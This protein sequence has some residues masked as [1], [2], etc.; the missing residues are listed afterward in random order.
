MLAA[1]AQR[2]GRQQI[3][4][5]AEEQFAAS[6]F[7]STTTA[8][9][10]KA[11][12]VREAMLHVHFGTRRKLF[13]EVIER[14]AQERV[15][16]LRTRF[17]SMPKL[18][19]LECV[20]RMAEATVLACVGRTGDARVMAWGLMEM[21]G[22]A[23]D[24]YRVEIGDTEALWVR[25]IA[26]RFGDG[27]AG[28]RLAIHIVPYAVHACMAFGLWLAALRH[29]PATAQAHASQYAGGIRDFARGVLEFPC[30]VPA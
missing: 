19:P 28:T 10:A 16:G 2:S 22:F 11:A 26:T 27:P 7:R 18:P 4:R 25:E 29:Q 23:A 21:P 9:L 13:K 12:G 14:N 17:L 8:A 3:V 6:G 1:D 30:R 5:A 20:E 15:A 24:V